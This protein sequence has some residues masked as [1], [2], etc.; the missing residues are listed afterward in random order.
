MKILLVTTQL[1]RGYVQGTERYVHTLG[2]CLTARGHEVTY[3]AG[4]P[5]KQDRPRSFGECVDVTERVYAHPTR[6]WM[7]VV[8]RPGPSLEAWIRGHRPDVVHINNAAHIGIGI[9]DACRTLR[10][11]YVVT[12]H[13][14]WWI[15]PKGTLLRPGGAVCDGTPGWR[16]CLRCLSGG[17]DRPWVRRMAG[18][19]DALMPLALATYYLRAALRGMSPRDLSNWTHRRDKLLD[20]LNGAAGVIFPSRSIAEAFAPRLRSRNWQVIANGLTA[21][22]F[23]NP[24]TPLDRPSPPEALTVGY[25]GA[26]LPHKAPHLLLEAIQ[27]LGWRQT[28]VRLAGAA[29]DPLYWRVLQKLADGLNVE[30]VGRLSP[31]QMP[32]FLRGLDVLAV[33]SV[34]PENYPYIV[35]EALAA[36]V[37]V[38]AGRIGGMVDQVADP[39]LL[40][41]PGS[42]KALA[43]A[44]AYVREHPGAGRTMK[45]GTADEMTDATE[46]V[47]RTAMENR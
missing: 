13:D 44:L 24:R 45:A 15:C 37:R 10:I 30:F 27:L 46:A 28:R 8:G 11:P 35:L 23:E 14:Y 40:F 43:A 4:D 25:A 38:V 12:V 33:T 9:A 41:E 29:D 18:W 17:H 5:L 3:L 39:H 16:D 7:S 20:C 22:W 2:H 26:I 42:A 1:G 6:G 34:W 36:G 31:D 19:P 47:Y 21:D 32:A